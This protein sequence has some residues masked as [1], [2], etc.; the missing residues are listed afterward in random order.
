MAHIF[1]FIDHKVLDSKSLEQLANHEHKLI[2]IQI[3]K[4][5]G[6]IK[7][8]SSCCML[9]RKNKKAAGSENSK[10]ARFDRL[11]HVSVEFN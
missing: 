6:T 8:C 5:I 11:R 1:H 3:P 4:S 10:L 2:Q 9:E 7:Q